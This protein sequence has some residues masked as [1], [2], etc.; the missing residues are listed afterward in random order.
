MLK[1]V[2][3][4]PHHENHSL[5]DIL[6]QTS[7]YLACASTV[8]HQAVLVSPQPPGQLLILATMHQIDRAHVLVEMALSKVQSRH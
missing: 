2:P 5:E 8:A 1:I 6:I 3:D 7:E 4:P